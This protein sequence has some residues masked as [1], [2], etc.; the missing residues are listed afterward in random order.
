LT[1]RFRRGPLGEREFRLLFLG[2]TV[3]FVGSAVAPVGLAFAVL[4][5]T[6]SK[7]DL[8]LVLAARS[9]PQIV[10]LL[11]GGVWSDRLPRHRVMVASS[12]LSGASQAGVAVLLLTHT[13]EVWHLAAL[14]AANGA[15]AAFFFPASTGIVPETVPTKLLQAA[16]ALL[17]LSRNAILIVGSA[18]GGLLVAGVGPGWTIAIDAASFA[19][20][21]VFIG[22]MTLT[23]TPAGE[24]ASFMSELREGW[25]EFR[26]RTWLWAIVLQFSLVNAVVSGAFGVLG[27]VVADTRLGGAAA[28][29]FILSLESAGLV[30]GGVF[31]L[32]F[33]PQRML[34]AATIGVLFTAPELVALGIPLPTLAIAGVAFV[35]G[36]GIE[37]FG[38]LWD[39]AMQQTIPV[40]TLSRVSSYD[41]LGSFV[42]MPVG[43]AAA[44]PAAAALGVRG[45][46]YAA[47]ATVLVTTLAVLAVRDVRTLRRRDGQPAG[48]PAIAS[49]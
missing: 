46:L 20:G 3:S 35:A 42:L 12:L 31:A 4:D 41:A 5:L 16:N 7:S 22:G 29:G 14:A 32:R 18:A 23:G 49:S 9:I 26:S 27:P 15:A 28:W 33:R 25:D 24:R 30:L 10:F 45:A 13:A 48:E 17:R 47:A 38:V 11:L 43:Q 36:A 39:T 8:G 2:R 37:T 44:G 34:L 19:L 6:G 1:S 21:A 40:R